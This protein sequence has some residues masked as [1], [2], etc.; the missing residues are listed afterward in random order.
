[1]ES[2]AVA[3]PVFYQDENGEVVSLG[4]I[5]VH[6]VLTYKRFQASAS[7]RLGL[8]VWSSAT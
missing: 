8:L 6:A 3:Y 1:M 7:P 2:F 4:H 5:G